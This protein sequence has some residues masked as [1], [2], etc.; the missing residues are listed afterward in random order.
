VIFLSKMSHRIPS[1]GIEYSFNRTLFGIGRESMCNLSSNSSA[2]LSSVR[3]CLALGGIE[4]WYAG[5]GSKLIMTLGGTVN[6]NG[7]GLN[8]ISCLGRE[9][10]S[11][12]T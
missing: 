4:V 10:G 8:A 7:V 2:S 3:S 6:G 12:R 5:G 1:D 9:L 11:E